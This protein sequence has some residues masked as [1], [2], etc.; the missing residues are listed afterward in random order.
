MNARELRIVFMGTPEFAEVILKSLTDNYKVAAVVTQP[1]KP[2]GRGYKIGRRPVKALAQSL[3]LPVLQPDK[4]PNQAFID[5][6]RIYNP[7][8]I[9]TAA[10][11]KILRKPV[12]DLP[13]LGC[14]NVHASLLPKYRGAAPI[15][16]AIMNGESETGVTVMQMD[17]GIDT[18]GM[19]LKARTRIEPYETYGDLQNRLAKIGAAA[20]RQALL[21]LENGA[22]VIEAQNDADSSYAPII[23]PEDCIIDWNKSSVQIINLIRAL[24]P[25]PGALSSPQGLKIWR[26]EPGQYDQSHK[27][28]LPGEIISGGKRGLTVKTSDSVILITE[29]QAKGGKKMPAADYLRGHIHQPGTNLST[30]VL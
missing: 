16:R 26:A 7:D 12:L 20:L 5:E 6:L 29:L 17:A 28:A 13:P 3:G 18:G 30:L 19:I 10:Y 9:V 15:Q 2:I 25:A 24:N 1:D 22:A 23:T 8:L 14:I 21:R 4:A 27:N 11:G